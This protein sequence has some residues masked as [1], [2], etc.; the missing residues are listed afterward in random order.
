[1]IYNWKMFLESLDNDDNIDPKLIE[2]K[3]DLLK[4]FE[5]IFKTEEMVRSFTK[6]QIV[7]FV[8]EITRPTFER[9]VDAIFSIDGFSEKIGEE[10][11]RIISMKLNGF[12]D[13]AKRIM[14]EDDFRKG[15]NYFLD[16]Y[17]SVVNNINKVTEETIKK[18]ETEEEIDYSEMTTKELR[19][20]IDIAL[21]NRDFD[22]VKEISKY[23]KE[24]D[25]ISIDVDMD[26][27]IDGISN[28]ITKALSIVTDFI[29]NL[30]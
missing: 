29:K 4:G 10:N 28:D 13:E 3:N 6:D 27:L 16:N 9:L 17:I 11:A 26:N 22:K 21:D 7:E 20:E 18:T 24:S 8:E 14:I 5:Q 30:I 12:L 23:I 25:T 1:M 19:N 2:M 15:S